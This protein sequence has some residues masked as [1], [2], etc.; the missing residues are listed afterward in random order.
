MKLSVNREQLLRP[1][2]LVTGAVERRQTL[3]VLANILIK[4]DEQGIALTGTDLEVELVA[5]FPAQ[6]I[7]E[8]GSTTVPA[9]KFLDICKSLPEGADIELAES[10]DRLVLRSGRSRFNLATLPAAEFPNIEE[11]NSICEVS[12]SQLELK[13]LID[14]TSFS[15]ANQDVRYYLNGM[16][17]DL[18]GEVLRSVATDGH[19]LALATVPVNISEGLPLQCIVPRKGVLELQRLIGTEEQIITLQIGENH[20]RA[21]VE[22]F[23]FTCKLVDGKFPDYQRVLPRGGDKILI[24]DRAVVRDALARAAIL[25]NEKFRGVRFNLD[26]AELKITAN[27]PEQEEA[28]EVVEVQYA[29]QSLEMGFNVSYLLDVLNVVNG[30]QIKMTLADANSSALVEDA[31]SDHAMYVVMPMRL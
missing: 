4:A 20:L 9:K 27:N 23:M 8:V 29:D 18:D 3:P 5:R 31:A 19:R 7:S 10:G 28:E 2:Q 1:L 21:S 14:S 13:K 17:F 24:A 12:L 25:S 22:G 6:V 26:P 16:L 30:E 11:W 15:M